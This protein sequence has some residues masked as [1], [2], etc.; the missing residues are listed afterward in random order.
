L[1]DQEF[2]AKCARSESEKFVAASR[3]NQVAAATA[4]QRDS[5]K[6]LSYGIVAS[7]KPKAHDL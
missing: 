5:A 3:R 1:H 6:F 4:P 2:A 7:Q